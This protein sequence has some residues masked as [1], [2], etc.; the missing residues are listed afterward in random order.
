MRLNRKFY[1]VQYLSSY[2][3]I[4]KVVFK[5]GRNSKTLDFI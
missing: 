1:V 2:P 3:V 4:K 5:T